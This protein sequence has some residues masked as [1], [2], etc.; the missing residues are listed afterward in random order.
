MPKGCLLSHGY[1]SMAPQAYVELWRLTPDDRIMSAIQLFHAGGQLIALM[2]ALASGASAA[3]EEGFSASKF[4]QRAAD[5]GATILIGVGPMAKAILAQPT[6]PSDAVNRVRL[7][8]FSPLD[9]AA[10][11]AFENRFATTV[12][13]EGYGQ[14][15]CLPVCLGSPQH[16]RTDTSAR[17]TPHLDVAVVDEHGR[18]VPAGAVGEIV[19][20]SR[21][22][23]GMYSGYWRRP[24]PMALAPENLWHHTGDNGA[25]DTD[26]FIKFVDR[27]TDSLRRRG[28]NV[29]SAELEAAI[30]TIPSVERVAVT[31]V[32]SPLGE[33]DIR[34][35]I[36]WSD[37]LPSPAS[38]FEALASRRRAIAR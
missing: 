36:V 7:A 12:V 21:V 16:R 38:L 30:A 1:L 4:M 28:E 31:A 13:I 6:L 11:S 24:D 37:E 15:E 20:R 29:S 32:R 18:P 22:P 8:N 26:G 33:D 34:A 25:A 10:R 3:F 35:T 5:T 19:V 9:A 23:Q 14:T 27:R 2:N 17:A